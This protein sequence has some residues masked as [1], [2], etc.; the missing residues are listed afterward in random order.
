MPKSYVETLK[1][2]EELNRKA[3]DLRKKEAP[4]VIE[5]MK[6]AIQVYGI[7]AADLGLTAGSESAARKPAKALKAPLKTSSKPSKSSAE[8]KYRD[9]S[10][11]TWGGMGKRPDW[12]RAALASGRKLEEFLIS[13][14]PAAPSSALPEAGAAEAS[15]EVAAKKSS[16]KRA[17]T[18]KAS[19]KKASATPKVTYRDP[20]SQR[21]WSGMGP[22]PK[23]LKEAEAQ[24]QAIEQVP[25]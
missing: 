12:L 17:K 18:K 19:S 15:T 2:I 8:P 13:A 20:A 4:G 6:Q 22:R 3:E 9:E 10:G 16:A 23:W 11:Q 1:D 5:R 7:T 14:A 24:G 21:T 25:A